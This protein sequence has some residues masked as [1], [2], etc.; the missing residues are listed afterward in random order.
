MHRKFIDLKE[1]DKFIW[2]GKLLRKAENVGAQEI[3]DEGHIFK[4]RWHYPPLHAIV[5]VVER[6]SDGR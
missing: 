4:T 1:G 3:D 2:H 6:K 5:E